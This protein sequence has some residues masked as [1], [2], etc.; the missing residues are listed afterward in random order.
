MEHQHPGLETLQFTLIRTTASRFVFFCDD[1]GG[2]G[3]DY[4]GI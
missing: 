4:V 2:A 1:L 3:R